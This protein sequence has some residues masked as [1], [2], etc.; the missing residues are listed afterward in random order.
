MIGMLASSGTYCGMGG[1]MRW[2]LCSKPQNTWWPINAQCSYTWPC[3]QAAAAA[4]D[5]SASLSWLANP[6]VA[7]AVSRC[8]VCRCWIAGAVLLSLS[9]SSFFSALVLCMSGAATAANP[10]AVLLFCAAAL[11]RRAAAVH[12]CVWAHTGGDT[13]LAP[14]HVRPALSAVTSRRRFKLAG[15][16]TSDKCLVLPVTGAAGG[17][18]CLALSHIQ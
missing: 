9:Q 18:T 11:G 15:K 7:A 14:R 16:A 4:S 10:A 2:Q 1:G 12:G 17:D 8:S 3:M 6:V 13:R 5:G